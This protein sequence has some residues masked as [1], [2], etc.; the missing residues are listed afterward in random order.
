[1]VIDN[2]TQRQIM[3]LR[4]LLISSAIA[5]GLVASAG[6]A[7]SLR[8][9]AEAEVKAD[10]ETVL[11]V[12]QFNGGGDWAN[13]SYYLY[14]T[15]GKNADWPGQAFT[16]GMKT[17]TP[18]EYDQ[19][20][21]VLSVD[22][23]KY[24]NLILVGN[25]SGWSGS[26]AQ[27]EDLVIADMP[28][29]GIYCGDQIPASNKFEVGYYGY[30]TKAV[31]LLDLKGDVYNTNHYCH[32]FATGKSGTSWPGVA[33]SK[34]AGSKNLYK[35]E[36]NSALDNVIFNNNND[37]QTDTIGSVAANDAYV[38]YPDNGYNKLTLDAA[39][40]IDQ[41]MM[42]ETAWLDDEGTGA[43]K[44]SGWY[45]AAKSAFSAKSADEKS[46]ILD[47]EPTKYRLAAWASAN[48]DT[49]NVD[50]GA[51]SRATI[52][53]DSAENNTLTIV[54]IVSVIAATSLLGVALIIRKRKVQ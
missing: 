29:N 33:M 6:V 14:G 49:F 12:N 20:Q 7:L 22:T 11:Y 40:F 13:F 23:S 18:N 45:S 43:C 8:A 52:E 16:D 30:S 32:T 28:N 15:G 21:Y 38:V 34:V 25:P 35:A 4:N 2:L 44:A 24:Q 42:F 51:F 10:S 53:F 39:S 5:L 41:Y 54:I 47:H 26:Q 19:Y 27:T 37:H 48:S 31:Y 9:E 1:M 17:A 36:I 50:T 46:D 3:K